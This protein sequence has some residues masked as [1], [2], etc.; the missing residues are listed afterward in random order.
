MVWSKARRTAFTAADSRN[1]TATSGSRTTSRPP[2]EPRPRIDSASLSGNRTRTG[3]VNRQS[4]LRPPIGFSSC[5]CR[6]AG[7][8]K[9]A[10]SGSAN[11]VAASEKDIPCFRSFATTSSGK[12][13]LVPLWTE[14]DTDTDSRRSS[15]FL[16]NGERFRKDGS[17][18]TRIPSG[19]APIGRG[20]CAVR[21]NSPSQRG[22]IPV[23]LWA[24]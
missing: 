23:S 15:G 21:P 4:S 20:S 11:A 5:R 2:S 9:M 8:A 24:A 3:R 22:T 17:H 12:W 7:M 1:A 19:I 6:S 16:R 14:F 18:P 13:E 10:A